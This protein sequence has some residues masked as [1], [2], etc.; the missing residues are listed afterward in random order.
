MAARLTPFSKLLITL[1]IIAAAFF[2]GKYLLDNTSAGKAIKE[3]A[4]QAQKESS[5]GQ[6]GSASSSSSSSSRSTGGKRDPNT[7][8]VQLVSW[9]GYAP[10]LYF[11]EG[12]SANTNSRYFKDYGFKVD[13]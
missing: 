12:A 11:N 10:G 4:E 6:S 5:S 7:I 13:F 2:G 9:G 8:K 1:L 3:K